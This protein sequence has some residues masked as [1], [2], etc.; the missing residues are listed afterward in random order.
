MTGLIFAETL[1]NKHTQSIIYSFLIKYII[2][3]A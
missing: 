3:M 1:V 2:L